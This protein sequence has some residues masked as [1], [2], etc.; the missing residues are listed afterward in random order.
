MKVKLC[1]VVIFVVV[2]LCNT[3]TTTM[4]L[5]R[6]CAAFRSPRHFHRR[7]ISSPSPLF[8][9]FPSSSQRLKDVYDVIVIGGG[10]AGCEAAA[11]S[12]RAGAITALVTQ[13]LDTIGELSCNPSIGGIGKGH[14]VREID[15]LDGI[16][17]QVADQAGIH[18]RLLNRRKG[19]AVRGP[20]AQMDRDLYKQAM[21][22]TLSSLQYSENLHLI[23]ASAQDL[24]VDEST[25]SSSLWFS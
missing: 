24:L 2:S 11:A 22:D 15:A 20:R 25:S 6:S 21:Q 8:S 4:F 23:E 9:T 17:G 3:A 1:S 12:A 7:T 18:Y 19:P 5:L 16:M 10:H 13:R 14:L